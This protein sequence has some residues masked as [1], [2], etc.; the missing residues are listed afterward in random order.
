M[1]DNFLYIAIG[2]SV[3]ALIFAFFKFTSIMKKDAG[4]QEMQD[5]SKLIQDGAAIFGIAMSNGLA[6]N[7]EP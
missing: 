2:T 3:V 4:S 6:V 5:I 1:E 7:W